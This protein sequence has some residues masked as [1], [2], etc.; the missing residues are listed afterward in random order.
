MAL[1]GE[2]GSL[3]ISTSAGASTDGS[4]LGLA[5]GPSSSTSSSG[6][7]SVVPFSCGISPLTFGAALLFFFLCFFDLLATG[8]SVN[9]ARG[10]SE[11]HNGGIGVG[12]TSKQYRGTYSSLAPDHSQYRQACRCT[13]EQTGQKSWRHCFYGTWMHPDRGV[14]GVTY[15]H[16]VRSLVTSSSAG[17][18]NGVNFIPL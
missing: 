3:V 13:N 12:Q 9:H 6:V 4:S 11:A 2:P 17:V 7:A 1:S 14:S 16:P 15:G 8:M 10:S 18:T 5:S